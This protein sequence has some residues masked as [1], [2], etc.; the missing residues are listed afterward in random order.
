[1]SNIFSICDLRVDGLIPGAVFCA[2]RR[3]SFSWQMQSTVAGV[4]QCS[5]QLTAWDESGKILWDSGEVVSAESCG[6][7]WGGDELSSRCVVYW[8]VM[9][10]D[11]RGNCVTSEKQQ[12][13]TPLFDN[14]DWDAQWIWFDGNNPSI[15]SP[16]PYFRKEFN[17]GQVRKARLYAACRGIFELHINGGIVSDDRMVPGWTDFK[18][19]IQYLSY[20]VTDLLVNGGNVL[21]AV[22]GDGWYCSYLSGR[23]RNCYGEYPELLLQLEITCDDGSQQKIVTGPGWRTATGPYLHSDIYD[24]EAYDS[25]LEMPGWDKCG[26]DDGKW[27]EARTGEMAVDSPALVPKCCVPVREIEVLRPVKFFRTANDA[28]IWDFG[29]NISG[30]IRIKNL[31]SYGG[32]L[33]TI[34]YGEMFNQDGSL[35]NLNFR[36]AISTDYYTT[37]APVDE[38]QGYETRF[39][40]H[41]FR[42]VQIDGPQFTGGNAA[43]DIEVSAVVMHSELEKTG[44]FECGDAKLNRLYQNICW[45]QRDNFLEVPTDCPQRDERL[46]WTGDAQV[47]CGT[48]AINMNVGAFFRKYLTDLRDA[49]EENGAVTSIAPNIFIYP[50]S[51][52]AAWADA[53]VICPWTIY[54]AYGDRQILEENFDM[55]CRWVDYQ[56]DTSVNMLRPETCYGDWLALSPVKTPSDLIGSAYFAQ[57]AELTAKAAGVLG[58]KDKAEYY[59]DIAEKVRK[60]FAENY[61]DADGIVSPA[62]QTAL[63]LAL[64][65][66]MLPENLRK[67]NAAELNKLVVENGCKLNT[68]FVGTAYLN[69]ALSE[70][71]YAKTACDL[72]LQE[73]YP[74]WLFSVN[75]GATTMWERWNSYTVK[76]G[77]GDVNMNSFNHYAYGAVHEWVI[78]HIAGIRLT[79]PGGKAVLFDIEP[80]ERIGFVNS[81]L[82][83]PCGK[84]ESCWRFDGDKV[85]WHISAPANTQMTVK[86]PENWSCNE[87]IGTL[88]C[89]SYDF[90]LIKK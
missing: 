31:K 27:R 41:G 43:E 89:G 26:F 39:T 36:S 3:P 58:F 57:T 56:K 25:R 30:G 71:G 16:L 67:N 37:K 61:L 32:R 33:I 87:P 12:F 23:R 75:Q 18:K 76:D 55:M 10:K 70:N 15:P 14:R 81:S 48:A 77:F 20:D 74:S 73:E 49:Q 46:G 66:N 24:G 9:V 65:F 4:M 84:M 86:I 19:R 7:R 79:L 63:A 90:T 80:D 69:L 51:G 38:P 72:Y 60:A 59:Y 2:S 29:Q 78:R 47:F 35:Y 82:N 6:I 68:G 1:M 21:G 54:M 85:C 22:V 13:E 28:L 53:A 8:Q 64:H 50:N 45:G 40:F 34:R 88:P 44:D 11:G 17:T 62:T 52:A 42:Y 5:Y 83:T